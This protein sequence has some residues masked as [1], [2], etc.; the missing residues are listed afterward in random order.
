[1]IVRSPKFLEMLQLVEKIADW[2]VPAVIEGETGTGKELVAR[3][4]HLVGPRR[5][6]PF[7]PINWGAIPETLVENELFGHERGAYPLIAATERDGVLRARHLQKSQRIRRSPIALLFMAM[8]VLLN[9]TLDVQAAELCM[10]AMAL[11]VSVQGAV[12]LRRA[13][14][15]NWQPAKMNVSVCPGDTVRVRERGRAA[16]R[17]SN[18]SV[19]RLDQKTTLTLGKPGEDKTALVELLTGRTLRHH[20]YSQAIQSKNACSSGRC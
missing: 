3:A 11:V 13:N 17:L 1:M 7:V 4:L 15:T 18:E 9:S 14:E 2:D 12:E 5:E 20:P 8:V 10:P 19:V 6:A 16:L